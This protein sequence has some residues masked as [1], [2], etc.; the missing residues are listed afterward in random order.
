MRIALISDIHGNLVALDAVLMDINREQVDQIICLGDV[1]TIGPQP[2]QV[3]ERLRKLDL[4]SITGNHESYL[5]NPNLSDEEADAPPWLGEMMG[6]STAQL[7]R[8]DFD[9]LRSF[10][11]LL[12]IPFDAAHSLLCFHGSPRSNT[13]MILATTPAAALDKMLT[14]HAATV[15]VGGHSHVQMVR[16]HNG[17]MIV[18]VGSVGEPLEHMPIQATTRILPW[19]EYAIISWVD[20]VLG[21]E[22]RRVP[23]DLKAVKE[24]VVRSD[25][26]AGVKKGVWSRLG[27]PVAYR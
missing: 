25:M 16:Q 14:G 22:A 10:Q 5:L 8:A 9:Y 19:A 6:W 4:I 3:V 7:S 27:L 21:I 11:P 15:M 24:T 2:R 20:G 12:E 17:R 13:D 18:N 23:I 1:A 26:P